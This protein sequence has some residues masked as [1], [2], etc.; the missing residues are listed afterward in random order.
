MLAALLVGAC[1]FYTG[2]PQP[3]PATNGSAGASA[4]AGNGSGSNGGDIAVGMAGDAGAAGD[5]GTNAPTWADVTGS[6]LG[7][8]SAGGVVLISAKPDENMLI[9]GIAS[10]GL[11]SS[12]NGGMTWNALGQTGTSDQITNRVSSII[13][14]PDHPKVFWE[15]GIYIGGGLYHS[16]DDGKTI[17]ELGTGTVRHNDLVSIDFSDP[18]RKTL[19]LGGHE[20]SQMLYLSTD[21]GQTWTQPG[22]SLPAGLGFSSYPLILDSQTFLVGATDAILRSA[23]GGSSWTIVSKTGGAGPPVQ[24][25]D[26]SIYWLIDGF[27]GVM[28]SADLGVTW[29]RAVGAGI[30]AG[31]LLALPDGRLAS[32]TTTNL[33]VSDDHGVTWKVVSTAFPF[34]PKALT[35]SKPLKA[36]FISADSAEPQ[37]PA[38]SIARYDWDYESQ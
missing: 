27:A 10:D 19:L 15:T 33:I 1:T 37:I 25:P 12:T 16:A 2:Q 3:A 9:A 24:T 28:A 36:F 22:A 31:T 14:D 18:E 13:Y 30:V 35:Y 38:N 23:D 32:Q 8:S 7:R 21:S 6:L 26:G 5:T 34:P 17:T 20:Q 4:T 11:W 29:D